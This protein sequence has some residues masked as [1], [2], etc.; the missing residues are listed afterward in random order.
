MT[1]DKIIIITYKNCFHRNYIHKFRHIC[2]NS[3]YLNKQKKIM[4][5]RAS[6]SMN[7]N[8]SVFHMK[9]PKL[10]KMSSSVSFLWNMTIR[11]TICWHSNTLERTNK[12]ALFRFAFKKTLVEFP[13][14]FSFSQIMKSVYKLFYKINIIILRLSK[15]FEHLRN[16]KFHFFVTLFS[17]HR[18]AIIWLLL[19]Q[20]HKRNNN[21]VF[22]FL[23]SFIFRSWLKKNNSNIMNI[24]NV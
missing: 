23:D 10:R 8:R 19:P 22:S 9:C 11:C 24:E 6:D 4:R 18:Q 20:T 13:M 7:T 15:W 3:I 21:N 1:T 17:C 5:K 12:I 16:S 14:V 2:C